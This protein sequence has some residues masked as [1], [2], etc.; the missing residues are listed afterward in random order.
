MHRA[1]KN[2]TN[3]DLKV[4]HPASRLGIVLPLIALCAATASAIEKPEPQPVDGKIKWVFDYEEGKRLSRET[5]KP[6]F[7][8]FRCER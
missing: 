3:K 1:A 4:T 2:A 6:M 7:V 5:G 8:V